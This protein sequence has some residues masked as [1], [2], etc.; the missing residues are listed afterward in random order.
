MKL[1]ALLLLELNVPT[2]CCNYCSHFL[3]LHLLPLQF[4]HEAN[5]FLHTFNPALYKQLGFWQLF[6][7]D[8]HQFSYLLIK[9][10]KLHL[11]PILHQHLLAFQLIEDLLYHETGD[12][13]LLLFQFFHLFLLFTATLGLK[14]IFSTS[15]PDSRFTENAFEAS[16]T[17]WPLNNSCRFALL[18]CLGGID[19]PSITN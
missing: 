10:L 3:A 15:N 19:C 6:V 11:E 14:R 2:Q 9:A 5:D 8:K 17:T 7:S 16:C 4:N 13:E 18:A 12:V 1:A